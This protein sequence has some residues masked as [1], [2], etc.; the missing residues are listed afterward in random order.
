MNSLTLRERRL[1]AIAI[2]VAVITGIYLL[3]ILPIAAGFTARE[4]E[5]TRLLASYER[6]QR[7]I[8]EMRHW[9][10]QAERQKQERAKFSVSAPTKGEAIEIFKEQIIHQFV[11]I[12]GEVKSVQEVEASAGWL[13]LRLDANLDLVKTS[14]GLRALQN[15]IPFA[16]VQTVS[17]S[18]EQPVA[19]G[20]PRNLDVKI[21]I[22]AP[23]TSAQSQ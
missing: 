8:G 15:S 7:V 13:Q 22:A 4:M 18:A 19:D 20:Q 3:V 16:I 12:G 11:K 10:R 5:R 23:Y 21:E 1:V 9:R 6:N 17:L 14:E 2:L